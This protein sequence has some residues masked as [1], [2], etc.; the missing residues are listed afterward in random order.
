MTSNAW[1]DPGSKPR[2]VDN[3][4]EDK[5]NKS[6]S[7]WDGKI[8][9]AKDGK[10]HMLHSRWAQSAGHWGWFGSV[11]IH[12]V[13]DNALGPYVDKGLAYSDQKG[14]GHNVTAMALRDGTYA[15][16]ISETRPA[17]IYTA[18]S[19]DGPW[20]FKGELKF[21]ANGFDDDMVN[22]NTC[23]VE[24]P[25]GSFVGISRH[26]QIFLSTSGILG[27]YKLQ[28]NSIYPNLP[29]FNNAFAEDPVMWRSGG[30]YHVTVNWW[31]ERKAHHLMSDDGIHGWKDMGLAYDPDSDFLRYTTGGVNHWNKIER[32]NV[33]LDEEG[34]VSHFT[35]AVVD[36]PKDD[37]LAN[38]NHNSKVIVVPFNGKA[39]DRDFGV[40][41]EPSPV[42]GKVEAESYIAMSGLETE[43]DEGGGTNL[44]FVN[45]GDW[46]EYKVD[47][48]ETGRYLLRAR[49]ATAA[50]EDALITF[51][52]ASG[53]ILG[54][55]D[56]RA[57][58]SDGWHDWY[59]DSTRVELAKGVQ[60][61]RLEFTGGSEYLLNLDWLE[62]TAEIPV[63]G[64][65]R[66]DKGSGW[67]LQVRRSSSG[68]S[69]SLDVRAPSESSWNLQVFD[70]QGRVAAHSQGRGTG[71]TGVLLGRGVYTVLLESA[72]APVQQQRISIMP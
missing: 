30:K 3:G 67:G 7:Y 21:D 34:H 2:D 59:L 33:V 36:A 35:F 29:G 66:P 53:G 68:A 37:D 50:A 43:P 45:D 57:S 12:S 48:A 10:F 16:L 60:T 40:P 6:W 56:V 26:G 61:V 8:I 46:A 63:V 54:R 49:L 27:P 24:R 22:S 47:V 44:G 9:Q 55:L 4:I 11:A 13:S 58:S 42:P 52:S 18:S 1:G 39:F 15:L 5:T 51:K 23:L 38:D 70:L 17:S 71:S 28:S 19:L 62:F 14:K 64:T 72:G 20:T 31:A 41:E 25:D 69:S 65:R 32:P